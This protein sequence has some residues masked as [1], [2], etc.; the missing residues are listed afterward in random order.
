MDNKATTKRMIGAVVLVLVAALL[1]AWLLKGKNREGQMANNQSAEMTPI[2]GF[3][4]TVGDAQKPSL[5]GEGQPAQNAANQNVAQT[6]AAGVANTAAGVTNTAAG[7]IP[8]VDTV[9]NTTGFDVRPSGQGETRPIV[10][11]DGKVKDGTGSLGAGNAA[12]TATTAAAGT[13]GTAPAASNVTADTGKA[14][15]K[16]DSASN[17]DKPATSNAQPEKKPAPK[18]VLVNE[19]PVPATSSVE[20]KAKEE[21]KA[22]A[23]AEKVAK[24]KSMALANAK[25]AAETKPAASASATPAAGGVCGIQLLATG[26]QAKATATAKTFAGE[27]YKA[28]VTTSKVDGKA[29]HRVVIGGYTNKVDATAAQAKMKSR[30]TQ[31]RDVQNSF[32]TNC[33]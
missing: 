24:E 8:N 23:D 19:K 27:G 12:A 21:A 4:G 25:P 6:V 32:V 2:L 5:V 30:Y 3:P 14:A 22:K 33:K 29:V 28:A 11:T 7:V 16:A 9:N 1:L 15:G 13:G 10:D 17:N 20:S 26:D 31:N 18:P